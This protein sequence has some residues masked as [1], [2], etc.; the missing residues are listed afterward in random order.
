MRLDDG[1]NNNLN[2]STEVSTNS[3]TH[4]SCSGDTSLVEPEILEDMG[5][6]MLEDEESRES[7]LK[8]LRTEEPSPTRPKINGDIPVKENGVYASQDSGLYRHS[9]F[10]TV[11]VDKYDRFVFQNYSIIFNLFNNFQTYLTIYRAIRE[12]DYW[13]RGCF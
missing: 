9:S 6:S 5:V 7:D 12:R 3:S 1:C 11:A 10:E 2:E 8:K 4:W 13:S